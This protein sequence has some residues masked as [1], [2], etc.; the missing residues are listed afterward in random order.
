L[1]RVTFDDWRKKCEATLTWSIFWHERQK[2][3]TPKLLQ[4]KK[5]TPGDGKKHD[6]KFRWPPKKSLQTTWKIKTPGFDTTNER[7]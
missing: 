7:P 3:H 6:S 5:T 4:Q 1:E 2:K